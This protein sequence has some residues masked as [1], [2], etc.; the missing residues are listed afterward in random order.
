MRWTSIR[1]RLATGRLVALLGVVA[2]IVL[3]GCGGEDGELVGNKR[4]FVRLTGGPVEGDSVSY[5]TEFLWTGWDDDGIIDRYQY[6]IDIPDDLLDEIDNP[7]DVGI[8]WV[9]TTA[10]RARFLFTTETQDSVFGNPVD[11]YRGD[12]TFFVRAVD[13]EGSISSADYVNFTARTVTPRTT[14]TVPGDVMGRDLLVV[15]RQFNLGWQGFDPDNPDPRRQPAFYEWKL[16][17][18]PVEWYPVNQNAQYAVDFFAADVPWNRIGVDTTSLRLSLQTPHPYILAV[19]GVDEAGGVERTYVKGRNTLILQALDAAVGTP[20]LT[21][22]DRSLGEVVFPGAGVTEFEMAVNACV[23]FEMQADAMTY[24]GVVQGYNYG[25]DVDPDN[26]G[27]NSAFRGWSLNRMT[28]PICFS[29]RGI[30]TVTFKVRDTGGGVTTGT[31]ILRVV[32][33]TFQRDVLYVDDLR[34]SL[35]QGISD[36]AADRRITDMI[37][38]GGID[39]DDP[40]VFGQFDA[41][42]PM[43]GE[44]NPIQLRLSEIGGYKMLLWDTFSTAQNR[45]SLLVASNACATGK[46]LQAYVAGGGGLWVWGQQTFGGF[47]LATGSSCFANLAYVM[48]DGTGG[49]NFA[50]GDFLYEFMKM[51]GGGIQNIRQNLDTN[52]LTRVVPARDMIA[53][54]NTT[55]IDID[56]T[57]Y[58]VSVP[59][60]FGD[61]MFTPTFDP[62]GGLD[63][64]YTYV[65]ARP[66]TSPANGR[67]NAFRYAD[68]NPMPAQG[69]VAVFGFP[70]HFLQQGSAA[71]RSGT[72]GMARTMLEWLRRHHDRYINS[73]SFAAGDD[74]SR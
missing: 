12:H 66:T 54:G 8:A 45:N 21:I 56:R 63:T 28:D 48:G 33:F 36:A 14:I 25:V 7:E 16:K 26:D 61:A 59:I 22:R 3:G 1:N 38:A 9:D 24:G 50:A 31:I 19:R 13:N 72:F 71:D 39:V 64:L 52:G 34:R 43:D 62:T 17:Q 44:S 5:T 55:P 37:R 57:F 49:L 27:P 67:P 10:F 41:W 35:S 18:M 47:D 29:T 46:I 69:P 15:G 4:P 32:D 74:P 65:A 30:H 20:L 60:N 68:P 73:R 11:Q 42:G 51:N 70:L 53:E 2:A 40:Q 58:T 6:A 23:R